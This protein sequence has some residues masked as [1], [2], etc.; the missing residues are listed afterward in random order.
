MQLSTLTLLSLLA[1]FAPAV[2]A[3]TDP[4][5]GYCIDCESNRP[6]LFRP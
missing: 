4:K 1:G 6:D 2:L 5:N 3:S